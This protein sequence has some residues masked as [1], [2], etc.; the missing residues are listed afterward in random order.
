MNSPRTTG[1]RLGILFLAHLIIGLTTPYILLQP[2]AASKTLPAT[3]TGSGFQVR[4]AVMLLFA[5]GAVTIAIAVTAW[6]IFRHHASRLGIW[7]IAL[8]IANFALQCTEIAGYM[9][10]F[11]F[12]H[13]YATAVTNIA[14]NTATLDVV[15][16]A[17]RQTWKWAHYSHLLVMVSWMFLLFA[18]LWRT[19]S[20]PKLLAG[21]AML[22]ALMQITGI[23][24]P[25][26]IPYPT[27][28]ATV[29]G[30]PLAFAYVALAIWLM[31]KGID[32]RELITNA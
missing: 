4:L 22:T 27:P 1:R 9:T 12:S 6:P 21:L 19:A 26:F 17:V 10:M 15:G 11:S 31:V 3:S 2:L 16:F 14:V 29:M 28:P 8:A 13:E 24:L 7:V 32:D 20:V 30:M 25:Q 18:T 23:S 5:G